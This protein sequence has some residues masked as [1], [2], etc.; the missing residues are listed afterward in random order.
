MSEFLSGNRLWNE[1]DKLFGGSRSG[2]GIICNA[3]AIGAEGIAFLS[4]I[5]MDI[6]LS[7]FFKK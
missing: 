3:E 5:L 7:E 4:E 6:G 1:H 2:F